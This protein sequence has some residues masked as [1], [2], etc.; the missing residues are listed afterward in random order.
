MISKRVSWCDTYLDK[1]QESHN[2][3]PKVSW[4]IE[5]DNMPPNLPNILDRGHHIPSYTDWGYISHRKT[6]IRVC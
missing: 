6:I 4:V 5:E 1:T 3:E 2:E